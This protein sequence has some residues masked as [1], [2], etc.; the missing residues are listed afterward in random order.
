LVTTRAARAAGLRF[1]IPA[2]KPA[3]RKEHPRVVEVIA[4]KIAGVILA[5]MP[6]RPDGV[7]GLRQ[8]VGGLRR[9]H[10]SDLTVLGGNDKLVF[11]RVGKGRTEAQ[12]QRQSGRDNRGQSALH[13][14]S[15]PR[16]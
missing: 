3:V 11:D 6:A 8:M 10:E 14:V 2:I 13:V 4:L 15:S 9:G 16:R 1:S 5:E 12:A 7:E